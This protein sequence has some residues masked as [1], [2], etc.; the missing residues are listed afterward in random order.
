M[1]SLL[2]FSHAGVLDVNRAIFQTL[3]TVSHTR[4]RMVVPQ[5]WKG[6]LIN[7]LK[8]E[9]SQQDEHIEVFPLPVGFSGNGSLFFYPKG[10]RAAT[11]GFA[12]DHVF[13]DEEPWSVAAHQVF[14]ACRAYS[15]SFFTKQNLRK[16][17]PFL[18]RYSEQWVFKNSSY[19]FSISDEVT[20][21]LKWKNYQKKIH[22]LPHSYDP[23]VFQPFSDRDRFR[24]SIGIPEDAIVVGYFGRLVP[25]KGILDLLS[26]MK[27]ILGDSTFSKVFFFCVGNG[28]LFKE[29]EDKIYDLPKNR[30]LLKSAIPHH[31]VGRALAALDV[32]VLPSLTTPRWKEQFGR[33]LVE[34][35]ACGVA[36]V[37]S[38]SGEIPNLIQ[39]TGGGVVFTEANQRELY[40]RIIDLV[41]DKGALGNFKKSGLAYVQKNLTHEA[42]ARSFASILGFSLK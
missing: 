17:I 12:P 37:G 7:D 15:K 3:A 11:A 40:H 16:K 28:P 41:K 39:K 24:R 25:E 9:P 31:E 30:A 29:V 10:L 21:V 2:V 32:L 4:V 5:T 36:V 22:H 33:I 8:Y 14:S 26:V 35:M 19:A 42:V 34:A 20:E 1:N 27:I 23:K 13:V 6:D 18:F 38:S